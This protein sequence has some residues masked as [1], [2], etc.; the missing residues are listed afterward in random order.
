MNNLE[1]IIKSINLLSEF[2]N[3]KEEL[4][5][6]LSESDQIIS[7]L[8]HYLEFETFNASKGYKIAK[9]IKEVRIKR[10]EIKNKLHIVSI[11]EQSQNKLINSSNRVM[12]IATLIK[13]KNKLENQEYNYRILD[14][15][16]I[17]GDDN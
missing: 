4:L 8:L 7:D 3:S 16:N 12:L 5:N 6:E 13:E 17:I 9:K 10:R 2:V 11:F 14:K 15:N 1:E